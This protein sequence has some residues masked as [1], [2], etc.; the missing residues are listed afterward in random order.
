MGGQIQQ[1]DL[2]GLRA[3]ATVPGGKKSRTGSSRRAFPWTTSWAS[4]SAVKVLVM[5]PISKRE[6][7]FAVP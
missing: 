7:G 2:F 6:S 4:A 5:E 1:R 3:P